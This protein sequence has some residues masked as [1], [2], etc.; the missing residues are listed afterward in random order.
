MD[1]LDIFYRDID[2]D[3]R[4][5][6]QSIIDKEFVNKHGP[7]EEIPINIAKGKLDASDQ[8]INILAILYKKYKAD[9]TNISE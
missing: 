9:L 6:K 8:I 4:K 1:I 7:I 5:Y 3:V 2:K